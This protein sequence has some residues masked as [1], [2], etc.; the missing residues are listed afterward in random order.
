MSAWFVSKLDIDLLVT[1]YAALKP[2]DDPTALGRMLWAENV[3]SLRCRYPDYPEEHEEQDSEVNAYVYAPLPAN[4][5]AV[6]KICDFYD[7]QTCEHPTYRKSKAYRIVRAIRAAHPTPL[8][9][10]KDL[11]W[12]IHGMVDLAAVI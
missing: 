12:G 6:S 3:K 2:V 8:E 10:C 11:P 1:A 7:Y 9:Q 4:T 5:R